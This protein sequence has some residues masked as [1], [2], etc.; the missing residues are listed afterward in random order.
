MIEKETFVPIQFFEKESY[1]GSM[2]GLRYRVARKEKQFEVAVYPGPY[3]YEKTA[4]ELKRKEMFPFTEE[5]LSLVIDWINGQ[6][7]QN[8]ENCGGSVR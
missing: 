7:V 4:E 6:F 2:K 3:C 5:G 1:T 8:K